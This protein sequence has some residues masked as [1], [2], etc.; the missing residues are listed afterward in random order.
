MRR[1]PAVSSP[2]VWHSQFERKVTEEEVVGEIN[3]SSKVGAKR[4]RLTLDHNSE[5]A[6]AAAPEKLYELNLNIHF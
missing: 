4:Q 1:S 2:S 6:A 5:A 3:D